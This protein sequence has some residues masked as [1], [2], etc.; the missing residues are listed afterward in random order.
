MRIELTEEQEQAVK[1][2]DAVQVSL[3]DL[4][5]SVV[6]LSAQRY[7]QFLRD[8]LLDEQEQ[9]AWAALAR[10]AVKSWAEENPF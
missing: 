7:H 9:E 4:G 6:L 10:K 5:G 3:P 2:G 8:V 1:N